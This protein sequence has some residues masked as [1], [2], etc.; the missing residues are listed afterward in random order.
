[1]ERS[2]LTPLQLGASL[3]LE[4]IKQVLVVPLRVLRLL[5]KTTLNQRV[6][7]QSTAILQEVLL[8]LRS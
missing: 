8:A 3:K 1:M 4:T 7:L 2:S 6:L 5:E